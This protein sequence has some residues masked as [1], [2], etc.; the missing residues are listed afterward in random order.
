MKLRV[1][2]TSCG[3]TRSG[4]EPRTATTLPTVECKQLN[5]L[6]NRAPHRD[7]VHGYEKTKKTKIKTKIKSKPDSDQVLG[8]RKFSMNQTTPYGN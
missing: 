7:N 5:F 3:N 8:A 2:R 1:W 6:E 4:T